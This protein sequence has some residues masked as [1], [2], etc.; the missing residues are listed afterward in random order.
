[1]KDGPPLLF[2]LQIHEVFRIEK[3]CRVGA[4]IGAADLRNDLRNFRE[5]GKYDPRIV[6]DSHAFGWS[7]ARGKSAAR[8]NRALVQMGQKFR[9]NHTAERQEHRRAKRSEPQ[10]DGKPAMFDG[11]PQGF[12]IRNFQ[13]LHDRVL[14]FPN[15]VRE[16]LQAKDRREQHGENQ[17][18]D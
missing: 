3:A 8:P 2:R 5:R 10:P 4:V 6:R 16:G 13:I 18:T 12:A 9:T 15:A 1:M 14:P 17:P 11:F 7:G